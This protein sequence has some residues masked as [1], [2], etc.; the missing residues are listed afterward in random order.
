VLPLLVISSSRTLPQV[1]ENG[2][3]KCPFAS[4]AEIPRLDLTLHL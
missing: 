1:E 2:T 3:L 4:I